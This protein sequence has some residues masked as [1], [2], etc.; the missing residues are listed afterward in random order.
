MKMELLLKNRNIHIHVYM[1][2]IL[3]DFFRE[4]KKKSV[5]VQ[6]YTYQSREKEADTQPHWPIPFLKGIQ[7][8]ISVPIYIFRHSQD[9]TAVIRFIV[10]VYIYKLSVCLRALVYVLYL[11][12]T[13]PTLVQI[14]LSW[15]SE[16]TK[17]LSFKHRCWFQAQNFSFSPKLS[18]KQEVTLGNQR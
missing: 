12:Q 18:L 13:Q 17:R 3:Q 15:L 7:N 4:K 2:Y 9:Y 11:L 1:Y 16:V 8:L 10:P 5:P 14:P 6:P